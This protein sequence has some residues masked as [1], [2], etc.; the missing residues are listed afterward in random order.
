M[1]SK[2][3]TAQ[4]DPVVEF[5]VMIDGGDRW[6][7]R[8]VH[9]LSMHGNFILGFTCQSNP[10]YSILRFLTESPQDV[11]ELLQVQG[12]TFSECTVVVVRIRSLD[13]MDALFRCLANNEVT[14]KY[15]YSLFSGITE[16]HGI[17]LSLDND[18]M[19]IGA[20]TKGGFEV[21]SPNDFCR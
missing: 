1:E 14:L 12:I 4:R 3:V 6:M 5:T 17:V 13:Q 9:M 8:F 21:L 11:R 20:L 16:G 18:T 19:A 7:V 15:S 10:G 2:S